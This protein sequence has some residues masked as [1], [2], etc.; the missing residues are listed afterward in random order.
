[1]RRLDAAHR[2]RWFAARIL[3]EGIAKKKLLPR[4]DPSNFGRLALRKSDLRRSGAIVIGDHRLVTVY[5]RLRHCDARPA[6]GSNAEHE[7]V[8]REA[9]DSRPCPRFE[10]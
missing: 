10:A 6:R 8:R 1:M 4:P 2:R 9:R 3:K 7:V 5:A